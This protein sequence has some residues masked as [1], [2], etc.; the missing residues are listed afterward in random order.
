MGD[1]YQRPENGVCIF[2]KLMAKFGA[3][4]RQSVK[5]ST[6][7]LRGAELKARACAE[8]GTILSKTPG[9]TST[10]QE[11]TC[12][13]GEI[14]ADLIC[15]LYFAA[16]AL[17]RP[18][19]MVLRRVLDLGAATVYLWDL[20]HAFW[21]WKKHD[22]DLNFNQMLE[23]FGSEGYK[24]YLCAINPKLCVSQL[25]DHAGARKVYRDL[26][27]AIHGKL[28]TFESLLPDRFIH[29]AQDWQGHL[30]LVHKV[31][32]I[33]LNLWKNRFGEVE[34]SLVVTMPQLQKIP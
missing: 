20:P 1:L 7:Q 26:S 34:R 33:L 21:G 32:D 4:L 25:L 15:S 16:C 18:A 5:V 8:V 29:T 12:I 22:E 13:F 27:N 28:T 10:Q 14:F 24:T 19:Q 6:E 3:N 30:E 2:E 11:I 17:D 31:E 9:L 23:H